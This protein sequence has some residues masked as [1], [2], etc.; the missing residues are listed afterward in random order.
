MNM[1]QIRKKASQ[2]GVKP[3]KL[4]KADLI[5]EIQKAEGN[6]S[7]FGS[8]GGECDQQNCCFRQDCL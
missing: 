5:R 1:Q 8:S 6:P 2:T 7:C 3:G 4:K